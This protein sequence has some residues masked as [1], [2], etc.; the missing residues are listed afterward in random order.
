MLYPL[1]EI[2]SHV[3]VLLSYSPDSKPLIDVRDEPTLSINRIIATMLPTAAQQVLLTAPLAA[4]DTLR[5]LVGKLSWKEL[6]MTSGLQIP[7]NVGL[8]IP[9]NMKHQLAMAFLPLPDDFLRLACIQLSDWQRP[10]H[11]ITE[12]SPEYDLQ[13]SRF[14]GVRGNPQRP[15]AAIVRYSFGLVV[16]LYSSFGGEDVTIRKALYVP[17]P[18]LD[19]DRCID[20]PKPLFRD[21]MQRTAGMVLEVRGEE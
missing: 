20:L 1:H 8:Q 18:H 15:V 4:I 10:A 6:S 16:E 2:I 11:I 21:I 13:S 12:E 3:R 9:M 14:P 17:Q 7:M 5:P 19:A